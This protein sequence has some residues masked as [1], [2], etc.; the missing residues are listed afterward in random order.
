MIEKRIFPLLK[1]HAG[2]V[3]VILLGVSLKAFITFVTPVAV[4]EMLKAVSL[5]KPSADSLLF[6]AG[7]FAG[8]FLLGYLLNL[9]INYVYLKFS[10]SFKVRFSR[11][12]YTELFRMDYH[13]FQGRESAYFVSR[14]KQFT[15]QAFSLAA[16]SLPSGVVSVLT[17]VIAIGFI[18]SISKALFVL[19]VLLLPLNFFGYRSLNKRLKEKSAAFQSAYADNF[20]N[21]LGVAQNIESIKQL[22]NYPF[23]SSFVGKYVENMER[24]ANAITFFARNASIF[25]MFLVEVLKNGILL[26]AIYLLY[27]KQVAFPDIMFLMMIMNIYFGALAD[28]TNISLGMRDVR[29][30]FDF[31]EGELRAKAEKDGT[32]E[33]GRVERLS[34]GMAGFSYDGKKD[35]IKNFEL[36]LKPGDSVAIVGRS[37]C[38][39][40]TL[41]KLL[42]RLYLADG[43][44]LNGRDAGEYSLESL[45]K[46]VYHVAQNPQ[47]FPG[48]IGEN[49]TAG[50][51]AP[52]P[53]R[54][55][56]VVSLPFMKDILDGQEG[57]G[58]VIRDGGSN[59]SG[60]QKQRITLARMLMHDPDV[61]LLD[62][63]TSALD[64]AAEESLLA[65]VQEL[66]RGKILIYVSHRLST[67]KQAGRIVVMKDGVVDAAGSFADLKARDGEFRTI[68]AAQ[69]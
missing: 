66:C 63:S 9:A 12:L 42:T 10:F 47:L 29:A 44:S 27:L 33:L 26:G 64:G 19:A 48:T 67:V 22:N 23:F 58:L 57:L 11:E 41:G 28:M 36:D 32:G 13:A 60:G 24:E 69:M 2:Y 39:K 1:K 17:A 21:I 18:W 50:L 61:V 62:E 5:P 8:C 34:F 38:G 40:S 3:W 52:D 15:D 54:Y 59:L 14:I 51:A 43:V 31:L 68:F 6:Y 4:R 30:G 49:I 35:V 53:R 7:V 46:K 45:R 16:D 20:K 65:S 37:G 25:M 56:E 55:Q